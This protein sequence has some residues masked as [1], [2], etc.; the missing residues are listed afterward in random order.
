[1]STIDGPDAIGEKKVEDDAGPQ[2]IG[3]AKRWSV[4]EREPLE[5]EKRV[6]RQDERPDF[7]EIGICK[8]ERVEHRS[9]I[10][11]SIGHGRMGYGV[12]GRRHLARTLPECCFGVYIREKGSG[13]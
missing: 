13:D 2:A 7:L 4:G 9:D 5:S 10:R 3:H 6:R 8:I 12:A 11:G 1:M